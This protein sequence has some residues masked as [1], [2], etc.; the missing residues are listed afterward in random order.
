V[1]TEKDY[2]KFLCGKLKQ[3]RIVEYRPRDYL[4]G[5]K[6]KAGICM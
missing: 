1:N 2:Q 5:H 4:T 3:R 6:T